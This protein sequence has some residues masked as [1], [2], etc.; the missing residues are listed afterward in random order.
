MCHSPFPAKL[1]STIVGLNVCEGIFV[2]I[3]D[4]AVM[5][6]EK[7]IILCTFVTCYAEAWFNDRK[8]LPTAMTRRNVGHWLYELDSIE[9]LNHADSYVTSPLFS[10]YIGRTS[11]CQPAVPVPYQKIESLIRAQICTILKFRRTTFL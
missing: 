10:S 3:S 4:Y 11:F 1:R 2:E 6:L 8:S 9:L 7:G 5:E